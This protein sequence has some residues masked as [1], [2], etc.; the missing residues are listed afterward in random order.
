MH[1]LYLIAEADGTQFAIPASAVENV[2]R[3]MEIVPVP[4]AEPCVAGIAAL[5]S[6]VVT[7]IDLMA[8]ISDARAGNCAGKPVIVTRIDRHY[9]GFAVDRVR[10]IVEASEKPKR[11]AASMSEG[12]R[13][14]STGFVETEIG[15]VIVVDPELLLDTPAKA[16]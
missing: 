4:L 15:A 9:Y 12:W 11:V 3:D 8:A 7:V 5:R 10:D 16:A 14:A 6:R 13:K 1:N 2:V